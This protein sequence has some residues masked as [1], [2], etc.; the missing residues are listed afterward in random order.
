M[1]DFFRDRMNFLPD[2]Y[3]WKPYWG[4]ND[5]ALVIHFHSVKPFHTAEF[6]VD[7]WKE[8]WCARDVSPGKLLKKAGCPEHF[9]IA[10]GNMLSSSSKTYNITYC[11]VGRSYSHYL[12]I[13]NQQKALFTAKM[14]DLGAANLINNNGRTANPRYPTEGVRFLRTGA[15]TK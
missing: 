9:A 6:I 11:E 13:A 14:T 10:Y 3:N 2:I 7:H 1:L 15:K 5:A 12:K 4:I 8:W